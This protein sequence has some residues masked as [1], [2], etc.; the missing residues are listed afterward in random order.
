MAESHDDAP[1]P[2]WT[3]DVQVPTQL[4]KEITSWTCDN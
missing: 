3:I 4:E 1:A 2:T